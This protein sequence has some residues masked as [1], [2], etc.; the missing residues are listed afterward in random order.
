MNAYTSCS[1]GKLKY[2]VGQPS[3]LCYRTFE[4][5]QILAPNRHHISTNNIIYHLVSKCIHFSKY[6]KS[7][8]TKI[9]Y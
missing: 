3:T 9:Y 1:L 2:E 6:P 4:W 7:V 5:K 8:K